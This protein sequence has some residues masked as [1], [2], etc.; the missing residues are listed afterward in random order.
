M[1][2][3]KG[4]P[5]A[6]RKS[7]EEFGSVETLRY[8][9]AGGITQYGGY[10]ETL[11]PGARSSDR[12]WHEKEDEF[13]YVLSGELTVTENDGDQVLRPGD[14]ACWPAGVPNGHCVS[15]RSNAPCS[16]L[17]V[18]TR[19]S[20]DVCHYPDL[21]RTLYTEGETWRV[22]DADGRVLKSGRG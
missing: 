21:R 19:P 12:H 6:E 14:A 11:Q 20:H 18:G 22:E 8:S 5:A 10:V 3:R 4:E 15:N 16:Y 13:L 2:V 7:S 1:I 17:I 9:D